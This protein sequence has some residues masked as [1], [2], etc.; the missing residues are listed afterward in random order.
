MR[1]LSRPSSAGADRTPIRREQGRAARRAR[2]DLRR[3]A[4]APQARAVSRL[5]LET[6]AP[7]E[8][9]EAVAM[10]LRPA[11][12]AVAMPLRPAA[13][14]VAMPLRP[15]EAEAPAPAPPAPIAITGFFATARKPA[16]RAC[17]KRERLPTAMTARAARRT[18]A[19]RRPRPAP[20]R[21]MMRN[22]RT[23]LFVMGPKNAIR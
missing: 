17:A 18:V 1:F 4:E 8:A 10:P 5:H 20:T 12:E 6:G 15:A 13:E 19:T 2:V 23:I 21:P 11:A 3:E 14:A 16:M 22:A 9:V 7:E